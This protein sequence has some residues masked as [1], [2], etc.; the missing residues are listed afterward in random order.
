MLRQSVRMAIIL[1]IFSVLTA[2]AHSE[3][4]GHQES[5]EPKSGIVGHQESHEPK[6][7]I[8]GRWESVEPK[9]GLVNILEIQP[10][11]KMKSSMLARVYMRYHLE[12]DKVIL[13]QDNSN[14]T[15]KPAAESD[16][17]KK[18]AEKGKPSDDKE[19]GAEQTETKK[20][21]QSKSDNEGTKPVVYT[22]VLEKDRL[23]M[24]HE[25]SGEVMDMRREG[26]ATS[27]GS[28]VGHWSYKHPSGE[29]A[30]MI[31]DASGGNVIRLPLPGGV[32]TNYEVKG[33]VIIATSLDKQH[34]QSVT[35]KLEDGK[36]VLIDNKKAN[37]YVRDSESK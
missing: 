33:D 23:K 15:S 8:V 12:G 10:D 30:R 13:I 6:N 20:D 26:Q 3:I 2:C 4:L 5:L 19:S 37:Y 35:F 36:L 21:E 25:A 27:P 28:I 11:G 16:S 14:A 22:F 24:T 1:A 31:F 18:P 29:T 7:G 17:A 32:E 34:T 9:S